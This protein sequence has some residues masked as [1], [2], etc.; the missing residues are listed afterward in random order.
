MGPLYVGIASK[1]HMSLAT[2]SALRRLYARLPYDVIEDIEPVGGIVLARN[3]IAAK[4]LAHVAKPTHLLFVDDDVAGF[5]AEDVVR[6]VTSGVDVVGAPLPSR[7]FD[8]RTLRLAIARGVPD[9]QIHLYLSPLLMHL[10]PGG[11]LPV[12][13]GHLAEVGGVSTG[14]LLISRGALE[15]VV[16]AIPGSRA[17]VEDR[18]I[19]NVFDFGI[20]AEQRWIGEDFGFCLRW[21]SIGG[22]VYADLQTQLVH[23]GTMPFMTDTLQRRLEL[24]SAQ[25]SDPLVELATLEGKIRGLQFRKAELEAQLTGPAETP[26]A[27]AR[28][29]SALPDGPAASS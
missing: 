18:E 17:R 16:A 28:T 11:K 20:D 13:A 1:S 26:T 19:V 15:Q 12:R 8:P 25:T 3:Q 6:M 29:E 22:K 23:M 4:F 27:P 10:L 2:H 24:Q 5:T 14:F 7:E 21:R 9:E